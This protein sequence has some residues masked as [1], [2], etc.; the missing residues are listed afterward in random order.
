MA[1]RPKGPIWI[2]QSE[3]LMCLPVRKL[4]ALANLAMNQLTMRQIGEISHHI[5]VEFKM[6][7]KDNGDN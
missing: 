7:L 1:K 5:G 6:E 3:M 4:V 2:D